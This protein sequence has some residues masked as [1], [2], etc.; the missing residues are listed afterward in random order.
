MTEMGSIFGTVDSN[1]TFNT[2]TGF[3]LLRTHFW[4]PLRREE[5]SIFDNIPGDFNA[6]HDW[7]YVIN[8]FEECAQEGF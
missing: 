8:G 2:G 7:E 5:I 6:Q 4:C 1:E 3:G